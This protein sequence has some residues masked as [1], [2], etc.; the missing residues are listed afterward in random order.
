MRARRPSIPELA[1]TTRTEAAH[2]AAVGLA[3]LLLLVPVGVGV[4]RDW[5][6]PPGHLPAS[7]SPAAL[8]LF[9]GR[10]DLNQVDADSLELLPELG[11]ARAAAIV[12][13][14]VQGPYCSV[15]DL[16]RVRGIGP[17]TL[18]R[19]EAWLEIASPAVDCEPPVD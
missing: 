2:A 10:L 5:P 7:P 14:R 8:L 9:G 12:G 3:W 11:P 4:H 15:R 1:A 6:V 18:R 13:D 16:E 17:V 19:V